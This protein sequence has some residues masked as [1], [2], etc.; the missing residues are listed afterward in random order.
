MVSAN[1]KVGMGILSDQQVGT[2]FGVAPHDAGDTLLAPLC[3]SAASVGGDLRGG[4]HFDIFTRT[5]SLIVIYMDREARQQ[6]VGQRND[7]GEHKPN[8]A[9]DNAIGVC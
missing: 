7:K 2:P 5:K 8:F 3:S 6:R 4:T 1:P 9:R